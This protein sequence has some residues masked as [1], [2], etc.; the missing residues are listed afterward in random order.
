MKCYN[1]SNTAIYYLNDPAVSPVYYCS[2]CLP[3]HLKTQADR[4]DFAL[5]VEAAPA[6]SKKATAAPADAAPT[7]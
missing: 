3:E 2:V 4:G 1:C 5:P 7:A 6:P